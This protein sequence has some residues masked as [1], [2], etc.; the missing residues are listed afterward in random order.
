MPVTVKT[1]IND[2]I[3]TEITEGLTEDALVITGTVVKSARPAA[4]ATNPFGGGLRR[5]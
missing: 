1:G 4:A 2:G 5:F 3:S